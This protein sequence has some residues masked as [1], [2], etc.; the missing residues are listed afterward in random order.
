MKSDTLKSKNLITSDIKA[1]TCRQT[2]SLSQFEICRV[3]YA[4]VF[5]GLFFSLNGFAAANSC[6]SLFSTSPATSKQ[7]IEIKY[8]HDI[9][10]EAR[11]LIAQIVQE[12]SAALP[13]FLKDKLPHEPI[14][15]K[16]SNPN[17]FNWGDSADPIENSI[18]LSK[19]SFKL[20]K[21]SFKALVV[22]ELTHLIVFRSFQMRNGMSLLDFVKSKGPSHE[23]SIIVT[24]SHEPLA[25]L[26]CD[27]MGVIVTKDPKAYNKLLHE[28]LIY[29][30]LEESQ[31]FRTESL[32]PILGQ[33]D[34][35]VQVANKDWEKF[36][37]QFRRNHNYLNQTRSHIWNQWLS[38]L[39]RTKHALVFEKTLQLFSE[40]FSSPNGFEALRWNPD[41]DVSIVNQRIIEM[42]DMELEKV[43]RHDLLQNTN[44]DYEPYVTFDSFK[45]DSGLHGG[46]LTFLRKIKGS[47]WESRTRVNEDLTPNSSSAIAQGNPAF[48]VTLM[49]SQKA[50]FWGFHT[51]STDTVTLP[52]AKEL[53][54]A[55]DKIN[56]K[57]QASNGKIK[58]RFYDF[59]GIV[60]KRD[61][62]FRFISDG[63]LPIATKGVL[64]VHDK[65]VHLSHIF[66][67][68]EFDQ[69]YINRLKAK[70]AFYKRIE[71]ELPEIY[72]KIKDW[73]IEYDLNAESGR[74]DMVSAAITDM[75][76]DYIQN[77]AKTGGDLFENSVSRIWNSYLQKGVSPRDS[78]LSSARH[79]INHYGPNYIEA[80]K[81]QSLFNDFDRNAKESLPGYEQGLNLKKE[82]VFPSIFSRFKEIVDL[83]PDN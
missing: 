43:F 5:V 3:A 23:E 28:F 49:G 69:I 45:R 11:P 46:E 81:I 75:F 12:F 44:P 74:I 51:P 38:R 31:K 15:F 33:R 17:D 80:E 59:D 41:D 62:M 39:P 76:T 22:H 35:S 30:S 60:A 64:S 48:F 40:L 13:D 71:K 21:T 27:L 68:R 29:W 1:H 20:S 79:I 34:F 2:L 6:R 4:L 7:S 55:I 67:P 26:L 73:H 78:V 61:Y 18:N 72:Q 16:R 63:R 32:D 58:I 70:V 65:S 82:D 52:N 56:S 83:T 10:N 42:L 53:Q 36:D 54:G 57:I 37:P 24:K 47:P 14:T 77:G 25:E 8:E 9:P 50:R 66:N 19:A